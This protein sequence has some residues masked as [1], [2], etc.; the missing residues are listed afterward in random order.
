MSVLEIRRHSMR[1][2]GGGSQLSQEGVE[3]A[4]RLGAEMGLYDVVAAS[5]SPR[6]RETA[7]AMGFAVDHELLALTAGEG[8]YTA[9][10]DSQW[11][12]AEHPFVELAKVIAG[13]RDYHQYAHAEAGLW[14]DL[15]T[16]L[17]END[18]ALVI[19]HSG[20][21]EAGLVAALPNADHA[22]WGGPFGHCEGA[23][24]TFE[25]GRFTAVE[26]IRLA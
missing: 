15:L 22:S 11:W 6:S 13:D 21:L 18:Q 2:T 8:V 26:L 16:P 10:E 4:R 19:G 12:R 20:T 24:L 5:V 3:L 14:R 25:H 1:K 7:V 17:G 9:T 23:R